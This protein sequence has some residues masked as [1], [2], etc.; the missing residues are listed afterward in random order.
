MG[1]VASAP[2]EILLVED[3]PG[4]VRLTREAFRETGAPVN[5]RV[6]ADGVLAIDFLRNRGTYTDTPRPDLIL[7][8]LNLPRKS[9]REL[10]SEIKQDELLRSIPT[11]VL[12]T[13][14]AELDIAQA[15]QLGANTYV[16]KPVDL[17][18]FFQVVT[19]IQQYWFGTAR[20][21]RR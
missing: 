2:F 9:G 17:A 7:L 12:T 19:S 14:Q 4:D 18:G 21:N 20:L 6:V 3:N 11:I 5:L 13:S 15:Y 16:P 8:D 10:L 1:S